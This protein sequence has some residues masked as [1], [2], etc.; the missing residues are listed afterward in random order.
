VAEHRGARLRRPRRHRR[1]QQLPQPA[2]RRAHLARSLGGSD[3]PISATDGPG[4][5]GIPLY[6]FKLRAD[7]PGRQWPI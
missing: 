6:R 3:V 5:S 4:V 1:R 7:G 2:R